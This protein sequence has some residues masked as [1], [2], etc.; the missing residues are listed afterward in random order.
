MPISLAQATAQVT[1]WEAASTAVAGGQSYS[2]NG[3][4]LTRTN[5]AEIR[6]M[7]NYWVKMETRLQRS[8]NSEPRTSVSLAN[9]N[10]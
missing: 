1:A 4:T 7:L 9:F 2:I 3:R 5:A 10:L 6:D 8:A